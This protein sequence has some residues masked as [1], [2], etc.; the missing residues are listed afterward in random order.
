MVAI[1]IRHLSKS[2]GTTPVLR[3]IDLR[4]AAGEMFFLLGPSGCGKTTLLRHI[5][6]F[7][8]QDS[9]HILF[10]P[11]D[12]TGVPA[13]K[14]NTAMMFQSYALWPH[15]TV[16]GNI[17]YG[18]EERNMSR[19]DINTRV[20]E[21]LALVQMEELKDRRINQLSGGQQQRVALA[22]SLAVR[23]DCLLLDEPLSNLDTKLR[24]EMRGEIRRICK[25]HGLTAIYVTHDQK[26]A[27]HL[28]DRM[29]IME[30]G[31]LGQVGTPRQIYREPVSASV[32][33]F[34]GEANFI[35]GDFGGQTSRDDLH[36]VKTAHGD[37]WGRV[38]DPAWHPSAGES[39]QVCVRPE[40]LIFVQHP[41]PRNGFTGTVTEAIYLGDAAQYTITS[42][43]GQVL[44]ASEGN[45]R[46]LR[47]PGSTVHLAARPEDTMLLRA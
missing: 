32:A 40:S 47:Q 36:T 39:V 27:L 29:A 24:L 16:G 19:A 20:A 3:D 37:Y 43:Q 33:V 23:P 35:P 1:E 14:R 31:V 18:L 22:R 28:A 5:A 25:E 42:P 38:T 30:R 7:Y 41:E 34:I 13:H 2:F 44:R 26:E 10:G 9:G 17:A 12:M 21:S 6:G 46:E 11:R 8:E 15:L 4:I 45:P